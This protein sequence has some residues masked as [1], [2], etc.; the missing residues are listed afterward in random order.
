[1]ANN[2]ATRRNREIDEMVIALKRHLRVLEEYGR[3]VYSDGNADYAGEIA[4]KLRLL[5]TKFGSNRP[6]LIELMKKTGIE[7]LVTLGGPPIIQAPGK[8]TAGDKI[9]LSEYMNL[10]AVGI[11]IESGE[12]VMLN[13]NQ[14]VRAWAE[15]TGAS[16][17]DWR[18]DH[19][20]SAILSSPIYIGGVHGALRELK[21]TTETVLHIAHRFIGE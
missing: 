4:G 6:L 1:M 20:L 19:A 9:N 14:F 21:D 11:R 13:K 12:F 10:D 5:V 15:Q 3:K 16:H 7:P 18:M 17:E 2:S 8:P